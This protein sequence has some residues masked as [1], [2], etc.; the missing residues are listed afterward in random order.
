MI[1][2]TNETYCW[3]VIFVHAWNFY[4][5]GLSK[6]AK[7]GLKFLL[8]FMLKMLELKCG[9]M[10]SHVLHSKSNVTPTLYII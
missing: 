3:F 10:V 6:L 5:R 9:G 2:C 1:T 7:Y 4:S 8:I